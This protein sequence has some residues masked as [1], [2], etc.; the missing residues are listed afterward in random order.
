MNILSQYGCGTTGTVI[1]SV[2]VANANHNLG[3]IDINTILQTAIN[4]H[5]IPEPT[6]PSNA[7]ILYLDDYNMVDDTQFNPP[8]VMCEAASDTAF[9]FHYYFR[10]TAGGTCIFAVVPGLTDICLRDTCPDD[11]T[12][13]LHRTETQEQRQTQVTSHELSEMI[14]DPQLN[15]WWSPTVS[16]NGD[17]CNGQSGTITVGSNTWTVQK[18]YSR[19]HDMNTHNGIICIANN[20]SPLPDIRNLF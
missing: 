17:I 9:G 19:W 16:E 1:D 7:Y 15:A 2:F 6:N 3:G 10:T 11:L 18:M 13:S 4:N 5:Q 12:C 8:I 20:P 14:S